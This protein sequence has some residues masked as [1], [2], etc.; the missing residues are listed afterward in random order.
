M[1]YRTVRL[2]F[3]LLFYQR[4]YV[5]RSDCL[6]R[7]YPQ[8]MCAPTFRWAREFLST[9]DRGPRLNV[10]RLLQERCDRDHPITPYPVLILLV[11][12]GQHLVEVFA[13]IIKGEEE[14]NYIEPAVAILHGMDG[15]TKEFAD[16]LINSGEIGGFIGGFIE[17][18]NIGCHFR[19][20][21]GEDDRCNSLLHRPV[22]P[23]H[24][25]YTRFVGF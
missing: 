21:S 7:P 17:E 1:E 5:V 15:L 12:L 16:E 19:D 11:R 22:F 10:V 13:S 8:M 4:L 23:L 20:L 6:S 18:L 9:A 2:W 25:N 14:A 24:Y 3:V